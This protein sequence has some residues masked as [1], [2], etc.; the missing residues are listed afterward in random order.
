MSLSMGTPQRMHTHS[1]LNI[2]S[3]IS[4]TQNDMCDISATHTIAFSVTFFRQRRVKRGPA[5]SVGSIEPPMPY[6]EELCAAVC[7]CNGIHLGKGDHLI[8]VVVGHCS[9]AV[10]TDSAMHSSLHI[11]RFY[12]MPQ[13]TVWVLLSRRCPMSRS[14]A[15]L[16][17]GA[18]ACTWAT[19]AILYRWWSATCSAAVSADSAMHP[20]LC[21]SASTS[22]P[23]LPCGFC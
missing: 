22:C 7:G 8:Q 4:A 19:V 10:S 14:C 18:M 20:S 1:S 16:S 12:I 6:Q 5:Y 9:A 23:S 2:M 17:V 15:P 21:I 3:H 13:L 11:Q